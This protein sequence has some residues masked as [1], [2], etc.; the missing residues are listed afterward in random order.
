MVIANR[1]EQLR[2]DVMADLEAWAGVVSATSPAI[3]QGCVF[4]FS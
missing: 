1:S 4:F 2:D 3:S